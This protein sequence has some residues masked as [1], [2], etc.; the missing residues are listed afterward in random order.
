MKTTSKL[1]SLAFVAISTIV[2][3]GCFS[4]TSPYDYVDYWLIREDALLTFAVNADVIYLQDELYL[5]AAR[6]P[7]MY[8]RAKAVVGNGRF[9][10][11]ARVFSPLVSSADD[12]VMA[13]KWYLKNHHEGKRPFAF[14]G[15]GEGG[16]ILWA[17]ERLHSEDLKKA[18]FIG[19]FYT[20]D[21]DG[22]FVND[23]I[24]RKI[25]DASMRVRYRNI[26]GR[27]MPTK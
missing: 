14:I 18:G 26:W 6:L 25:K 1:K 5:D 16:R 8:A 11:V 20:D 7:A 9:D 27:E 24:V 10:G 12:V 3:A 19:G 17:Y 23:E 22:D 4:C 13:I 2:L 15:E 21:T